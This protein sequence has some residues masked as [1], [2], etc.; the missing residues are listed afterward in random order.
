MAFCVRSERKM[1]YLINDNTNLGPGQYFQSSDKKYIKKRIHPPFEISS[2]RE[3]LYITND[4]PGPGS[5]DLIDKSYFNNKDSSFNSTKINNKKKEKNSSIINNNNFS[6]FNSKAGNN[7][8][9]YALEISKNTNNNKSNFI[10][11]ENNET[12]IYI[13]VK[14]NSN[15]KNNFS[16]LNIRPKVGFLSK[17]KRFY[18]NS[19]I[20]SIVLGTF[21]SIS[22]PY[23]V[24]V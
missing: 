12:D 15:I 21:G 11:L 7:N 1:D 17:V 4:I 23:P 14:N 5:Y 24:I 20:L 9:S 10:I 6:V 13:K 8:S 16:S 22:F 18:Q 19:N 3:T 2:K